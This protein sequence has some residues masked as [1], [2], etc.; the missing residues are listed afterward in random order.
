[1]GDVGQEVAQRLLRAADRLRHAVEVLGQG[2]G[3]SGALHRHL[4]LVVAA[5]HAD[6]GSGHP[7]QG[8]IDGTRE[9][10]AGDDGDPQPS[11]AGQE[12]PRRQVADDG[13]GAVL[14]QRQDQGG[15]PQRPQCEPGRQGHSHEEQLAA[16]LGAVR[17]LVQ[18]PEVLGELAWPQVE[19]LVQ[20]GGLGGCIAHYA[21][22]GVHHQDDD[23]RIEG[24]LPQVEGQLS[25]REVTAEE[26]QVV[27][28]RQG[29]LA[30][31]G[32]SLVPAVAAQ[33]EEEGE[34]GHAQSDRDDKGEG[35]VESQ[36]EA[37]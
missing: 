25:G 10:E 18:V 15:R 9:D 7:L 14:G 17:A 28:D 21:P 19:G 35:R 31:R 16:V 4:L 2:A 23:V 8:E 33:G 12:Q 32:D 29:Y 3:F 5:G 37:V 30:E 1:M 26:G 27:V 34:A 22:A 13:A 20:E 36:A 24:L 11:Q 6:G